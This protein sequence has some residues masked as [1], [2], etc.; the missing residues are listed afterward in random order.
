M[1]VTLSPIVTLAR[2]VQS[3]NASSPMLVTLSGISMLARLVQLPNATSPMLVTLSG[4]V[5]SVAVFPIGYCINVVL[6]LLNNA[7]LSS[8]K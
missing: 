3:L 6:S 8:F 2:L 1:L 4:I 5:Y 7:P